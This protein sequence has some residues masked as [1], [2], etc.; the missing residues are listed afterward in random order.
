MRLCA[1]VFLHSIGELDNRTQLRDV[2]LLRAKLAAVLEEQRAAAAQT[3]IPFPNDEPSEV[4][5]GLE[6]TTLYT[7]V[8]EDEIP[9]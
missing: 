8:R 6:E 1:R 7:D 4:S 9:F 2:L 5:S 3:T